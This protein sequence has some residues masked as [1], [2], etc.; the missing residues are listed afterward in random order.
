MKILR[1]KG[2]RSLHH[3]NTVRTACTFLRHARLLAR[4]VVEDKGL[5]QTPQQTDEIDKKFGVWWD[6]FL[7]GVDIHNRVSGLCYYGPVP[8]RERAI[9]SASANVST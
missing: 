6:I 3:V 4:G 9:G 8:N 7:D 1:S 5:L 2:V